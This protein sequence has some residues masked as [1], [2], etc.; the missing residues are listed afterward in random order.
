MSDEDLTPAQRIERLHE[1]AEFLAGMARRAT[2]HEV[3]SRLTADAN[4]KIRQ[5][6]RIRAEVEGR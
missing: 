5:A 1:E 3:A 4:A 2:S 6:A